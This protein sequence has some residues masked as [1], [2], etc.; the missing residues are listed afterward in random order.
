MKSQI[1][2]I[3]IEF[4]CFFRNFITVFFTLIFPPLFL[5]LF[6]EIYGNDPTPLFDGIGTV[7]AS[8][9]AYICMVVCV[10]GIMSLPLS[11]T[12]YREK[13]I[14]KRFKATPTTPV[15]IIVAQILVNLLMTI[16]G[17]ALLVLIAEWRYD[18]N[19]DGNVFGVGIAFLLSVLCV[20]SI[21][22]VIASVINN[23]KAATALANVVYFPM[24]FLSGATMPLETM[25]DSIKDIAEFIPLTHAVKLMKAAWTGKSLLDYSTSIIVLSAI[26]VVCII[27]SVVF[28]RW[29]S[30]RA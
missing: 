28:F 19:F 15:Q 8:V 26:T 24:L 11:L 29:D 21:G 3:T 30:D 1:Q 13:K 23:S 10:T 18:I 20:F 17:A 4:K 5:I 27:V 14:L 7:D 6:G 22:F 12:S 25:P 9:P 2:W 16:I